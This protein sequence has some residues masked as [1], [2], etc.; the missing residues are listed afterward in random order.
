MKQR[1]HA[2]I[3]QVE[4]ATWDRS[5]AR[6]FGNATELTKH[7]IPWLLNACQLSRDSYAIDIGCGPGHL[8]NL[9][10]QSTALAPCRKHV[11]SA[12]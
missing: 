2:A 6:Y 8:A 5:A 11:V 9:M 3:T 1:D 7:A 12:Q 4:R 10:A